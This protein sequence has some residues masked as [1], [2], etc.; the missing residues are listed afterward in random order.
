VSARFSDGSDA[1]GSCAGGWTAE[2]I[3]EGAVTADCD[4][5][6][7]AAVEDRASEGAVD[8]VDRFLS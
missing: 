2:T 1:D 3:G 4:A 8:D 6:D 7:V 5:T